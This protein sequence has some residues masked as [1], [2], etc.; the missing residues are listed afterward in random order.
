MKL[1]QDQIEDR[2]IELMEREPEI[3][4]T[5]LSS[6]ASEVFRLDEFQTQLVNKINSSPKTLSRSGTSQ[7]APPGWGRELAPLP[8]VG[9]KQH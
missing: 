9:V 7:S 2:Y 6:I 3:N 5:V 4:L 8:S 1:T